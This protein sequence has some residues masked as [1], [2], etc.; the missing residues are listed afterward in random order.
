MICGMT[1]DWYYTSPTVMLGLRPTLRSDT[2]NS[3]A[4]MIYSQLL[5]IPGDFCDNL[6]YEPV[7]DVN[8]FMNGYRKYL[9]QVEP[10]LVSNKTQNFNHFTLNT[11]FE[12]D[13]R[14]GC[15]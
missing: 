6:G 10:V 5:R 11:C 9:K 2:G 14:N 3:A 1:I 8:S 13:V 7:V 12:K 4:E 15:H